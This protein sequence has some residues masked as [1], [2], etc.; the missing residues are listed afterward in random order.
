MIE[1]II[2]TS[3]ISYIIGIVVG[4]NWDKFTTE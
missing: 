3:L 1:A 2:I 4:R